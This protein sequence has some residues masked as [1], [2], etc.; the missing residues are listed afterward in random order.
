ML[1]INDKN[2]DLIA[3]LCSTM[4]EEIRVNLMRDLKFIYENGVYFKNTQEEGERN[5]FQAIHFSYYNRYSTRVFF[6][7][8]LTLHT[9]EYSCTGR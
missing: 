3:L 1:R 9:Y 7:G 8:L 4:P 5:D 2:H 6:G